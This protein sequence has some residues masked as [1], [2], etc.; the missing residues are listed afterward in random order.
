MG[1]GDRLIDS[2]LYP[3]NC[4]PFYRKEFV[5]LIRHI[6]FFTAK[7]E[8][9]RQTV[10]DGLSLLKGIPGC[11]HFEVG[12]NTREDPISQARPDFVVYGEFESDSQLA[13][14]KAHPLY[15][16]SIDIVRPLRD[17]RIAADFDSSVQ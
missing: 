12:V 13:A 3:R 1:N 6:V 4:L 2:G 7:R 5:E 9:D 17:M 14:F 15:Q 10:L 11:S 8:E 16:Q